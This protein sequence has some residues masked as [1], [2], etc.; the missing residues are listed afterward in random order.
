MFAKGGVPVHNIGFAED[1]PAILRTIR[2]TPGHSGRTRRA[3]VVAT[4][5]HGSRIC[6]APH[7]P[8]T[9]T[10]R[11]CARPPLYMTPAG[12]TS[13]RGSLIHEMFVAAGLTNFQTEFKIVGMMLFPAGH[14][15]SNGGSHTPQATSNASRAVLRRWSAYW[16]FLQSR[17]PVFQRAVESPTSGDREPHQDHPHADERGRAA[18]TNAG[19]RAR[20]GVAD[21]R[22]HGQSRL[23]LRQFDASV[24][25]ATCTVTPSA[26]ADEQNAHLA[27]F[28][29]FPTPN[30]PTRKCASPCLK[31]TA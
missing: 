23:E 17:F 12:V 18:V 1:F 9:I 27:G 31:S 24:Q 16:R 2:E 3:Q 8:R 28:A 14:V 15:G 6:T 4:G 21:Q 20:R 26:P 30:E 25:V 19:R 10:A 29:A 11:Q 5:M 13:E 7:R 22:T